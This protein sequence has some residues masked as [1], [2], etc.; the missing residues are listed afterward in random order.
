MYEVCARYLVMPHVRHVYV[1]QPLVR[2]HV[3]YERLGLDI[4]V[5]L[6]V[7]Q[8]EFGPLVVVSLVLLQWDVLGLEYDLV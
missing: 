3:M 8:L 5:S 4:L 2:P 1:L 7:E 6:K